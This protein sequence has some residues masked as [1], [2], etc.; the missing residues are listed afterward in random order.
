MRN[1]S[2][3]FFSLLLFGLNYYSI[4]NLENRKVPPVP[5]GWLVKLMI[6]YNEYVLISYKAA[7]Q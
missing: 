3:N 7:K 4:L 2:C 6:Y 1:D 5:L